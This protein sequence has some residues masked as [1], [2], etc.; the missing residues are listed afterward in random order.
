[1]P[2]ESDRIRESSIK[3]MNNILLILQSFDPETDINNHPRIVIIFN[4][5][6][7]QYTKATEPEV[8]KLKKERINQYKLALK[9]IAIKFYMVDVSD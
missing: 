5:V 3:S 7:C 1:M 9:T 8:E 2:D 4:N 6:S